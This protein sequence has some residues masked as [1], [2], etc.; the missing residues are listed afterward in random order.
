M[1][2]SRGSGRGLG[3][4]GDGL[5]FA[6]SSGGGWLFG[7]D[8]GDGGPGGGLVDDGLVRGERGDEGL[9]C[10]VVHGPGQAAAG[11]VDEVGGV[12]AEQLV[13]A[14]DELEVVG[15]V[16]AGLG[17]GHSRQGVAEHDPLVQGGE[18]AE[19]DPSAQGRLAQ[20]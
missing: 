3:G 14:A 16:V 18:A 5:L 19:L 9:E 12:V 8:F 13:A 6:V 4:H 7:G 20:E 17:L 10:E 1:A 15:D 2:P 11:L